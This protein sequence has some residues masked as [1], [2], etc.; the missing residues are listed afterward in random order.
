MGLDVAFSHSNY[1][2]GNSPNGQDGKEVNPTKVVQELSANASFHEE[3]EN[4]CNHHTNHIGPSNAAVQWCTFF[5]N[6]LQE[7]ENNRGQNSGQMGEHQYRIHVN[8]S[9]RFR[10]VSHAYAPN[11]TV[12]K[13]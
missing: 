3:R 13:Q 2:G 8:Q 11:K 4:G 9:F 7:S 10:R 12:T 1:G 6:E 5:K